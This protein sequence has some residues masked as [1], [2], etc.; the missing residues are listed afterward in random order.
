MHQLATL[1]NLPAYLVFI[2]A[3]IGLL[4]VFT[5]LY[6]HLTPYNEI[7]LIRAGN[8]AAAFSLGGTLIGMALPL[9]MLATQTSEVMVLLIWGAVALAFQ[10]LAF[11]LCAL[12][13]RD[14][15]KNMEA[16]HD[17][18]GIAIGCFS[19]VVG[20]INAGSLT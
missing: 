7:Q 4:V 11:G 13:L 16:G 8:R 12:V 2:S 18:Y 9:S 1:G 10:F 6:T 20:L 15:R 17:S 5:W 14:V 19:I 3:L